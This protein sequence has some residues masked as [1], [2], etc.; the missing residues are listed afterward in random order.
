M[1]RE[2]GMYDL[3]I[4]GAGPAGC[5]AAIGALQKD[6]ELRVAIIDPQQRA[7]H[8]VGEA[9]LTGTIL[10][11]EEAGLIEK[12]ARMGFHRKIGAAYVWGEGRTPW[13]VNYPPSSPDSP[14]YPAAFSGTDTR[15]AIHVPR[16]IF[17]QMLRDAAEDAGAD[18]FVGAVGD[19]RVAYDAAGE[20]NIIGAGLADG[21]TVRARYWIDASGQRAVLANAV[22]TR[23]RM[24][25]QRGA[26]FA[27]YQGL[28]WHRAGEHGFDPHRTNIVSSNNGWFWVIH[29]GDRGKGLTSIGFVSVPEVLK[30]IR[31][32]RPIREVFPEI[33]LFGLGDGTL[34]DVYGAPMENF[35][36]RPDYSYR[37]RKLHGGNWALAGDAALFLDPI[38]SQGV[39][40]AVHYGLLRGRAAVDAMAG[41]PL[42]QA[43]VSQHYEREAAVLLEVCGAWYDN[44]Q[45][46]AD[47]RLKSAM[48][49]K[50]LDGVDRAD[51]RAFTYITNLENL[52]HEYNPYPVSEQRIIHRKLFGEAAPG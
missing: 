13:Y 51:E 48:I 45:A 16:H 33:D 10:A 4:L 9:L 23:Q 24:G 52:R 47:W 39:T 18:L 11:L 40:L 7:G 26:K 25:T 42:S 37:S 20:S 19:V 22:T 2:F 27:Y 8:K 30:A 5:M 28:D 6:P 43:S 38:L 35:L 3:V 29:L 46:V 36:S 14:Q 49:G 32:D 41:Q 34:R 44:N 17:D 15:Y 12:V 1:G 31:P 50:A 21:Q